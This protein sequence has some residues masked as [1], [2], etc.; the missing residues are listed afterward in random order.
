VGDFEA[1][2]LAIVESK[3]EIPPSI[4]LG[5]N[6]HRKLLA[7]GGVRHTFTILLVF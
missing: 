6:Q 4:K 5:S 7:I 3:I 2:A 1:V